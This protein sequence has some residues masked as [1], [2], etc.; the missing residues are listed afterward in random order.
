LRENALDDDF[1]NK[2]RAC[3]VYVLSAYTGVAPM[4]VLA[5]TTAAALLLANPSGSTADQLA[6][7]GGFLLGNAHRC[8]IATERVVRVG[9]VVRQ[10]IAAAAEDAGAEN[11]AAKRFARFFI[12]GAF[13]DPAKDK[14]V[15]SCPIVGS[16][17]SRLERHTRPHLARG[18][19]KAA[20]GGSG[21][22]SHPEAG[23]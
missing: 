8:G 23:E 5:A 18:T 16:E 17:F 20:S 9:Q 7:D 13:A 11:D 15:A 1:R 3:G 4:S 19:G 12:V 14:L 6:A 21:G 2:S 22:A 10:L